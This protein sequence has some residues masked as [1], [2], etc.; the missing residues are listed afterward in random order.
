MLQVTAEREVVTLGYGTLLE[1]RGW[2]YAVVLVADPYVPVGVGIGIGIGNFYF[3]KSTGIEGR[4]AVLLA[5]C[6]GMP[7]NGVVNRSAANAV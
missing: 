6:S 1:P 7:E 5:E 4:T 2:L 3:R